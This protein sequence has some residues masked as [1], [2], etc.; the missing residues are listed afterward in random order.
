[1]VS[2]AAIITA[3]VL[4]LTHKLLLPKALS[5]MT[6]DPKFLS[7]AR[8]AGLDQRAPV[9]PAIVFAMHKITGATVDETRT[10]LQIVGLCGRSPVA[11]DLIRDHFMLLCVPRSSLTPFYQ[12]ARREARHR[13]RSKRLD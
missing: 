8:M 10:L 12:M 7:L 5:V 11:F 13:P 2:L 6:L 1:M 4:G 9:S 3:T